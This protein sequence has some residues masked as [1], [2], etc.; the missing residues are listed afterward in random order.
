[1]SRQQNIKSK[2]RR[3]FEAYRANLISLSEV[4]AQLEKIR[5]ETVLK[6]FA[7]KLEIYEKDSAES[8]QQQEKNNV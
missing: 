1:M 7:E 4:I 2:V 6:Q 8:L 3:I 5:S